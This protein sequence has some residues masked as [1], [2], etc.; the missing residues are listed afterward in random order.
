[1]H[2]LALIL[3]VALL[4]PVPGRITPDLEDVLSRTTPD[5]KIVV[6]IHMS[7]EY[8]Y[9]ELA[10]MTNEDK[11]VVMKDV[12]LNS[13]RDIT[14]YIR[15][16]PQAQAEMGGQF[17]IFNGFHVQ[18]TPA[19]IRN[20]AERPDV[21]FIC[22]NAT[23]QLDAMQSDDQ[24]PDLDA[25]EW[26][27]LKIKADSCWYAGFNGQNI[28]VG[29]VDTGVLTTHAALTGKWLSPYWVD[30]VNGQSSPYDD[31]SHGTHTMGTICGGDGPGAFTNDIGVAYGLR[32][33]P[34]KAFNSGGSGSYTSIDTCMH[35]LANLKSGG[36]DIRAIGNS[37]G[38][39]SGSELHYWTTVLNWKTL[40]VFP[41]FSNGNS[42]PSAGT[43]GAPGS[44]PLSCGVG[45]TT[46]TDAIA[47]YSS[48][49]PAPNISP[50][51]DPTY[52][53]YS[54][55]NL[56]KPDVSAPGS[57]IRS[58][59]NNGGYGSMDGTSMASPHVTGGAAVLLSKNSSLT[60]TDLYNL[61][62]NYCDQ[63]S[64]GG[65]YPNNNYGWGRI[66]LYRS[67]QNV[68]SGS[69]PNVT[70]NRTA[71][72]G[73]GN[74]NGKLDPGENAGIVAYLLNNGGASATNTQGTLRTTD[75]YITISDSTYTYGTIPAGDSANNTGDAF[76]LAVAG[77]CPVGHVV[78]FNLYIA[79]AESSWTRTFQLTVGTPG[80]DFATHDAGN[81]KLSIT[82]WGSIGFMESG[83]INGVGFV[84]PSAGTNKLF[85]SSF[86]IATDINYV[87][88]RYYDPNQVD[89]ADWVTTTSPDG[90]VVWEEPGP[91][92]RDEYSTAMYDDS[93]AEVVKNILCTQTTWG[94][95]DATANDF[96][97]MK[98]VLTNQSSG[99]INNIITG[100]FVDFDISSGGSSDYGGSEVA[101]NLTWM[102]QS[103]PYVGV[104]ILDPPRTTPAR[105]LV[106]I[107]NPTYVYPSSGMPDTLA[108]KFMN[109]TITNPTGGTAVDWSICNSTAPFNL[110]AGESHVV[111]Y[112]MIGGTSLADFQ[113]NADTAYQRYWNWGVAD[114]GQPV[115]G[116]KASFQITPLINH[117]G[118][119]TLSYA[120]SGESALNLTVYD[121]CGRNV[122]ARTW[123]R[124]STGQV[125]FELPEAAQ[126]VYFAKVEAGGQSQTVKLV[127][128]K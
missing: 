71:V 107:N 2:A 75:T 17:W 120:L 118:T 103:T 49:G 72:V 93:G 45:A 119:Y 80:L 110:N 23:V 11:C 96:V 32:F 70:L 34:T 48:R 53:Y 76:D 99:V 125:S 108:W 25:I 115:K 36:I 39:S 111:A 83:Q 117:L 97:I 102:Y 51:N 88:D 29:H 126:G 123:D 54:T 50:I 127:R 18:A 113:A 79:C 68:P 121:I 8:P 41:V 90:K 91:D 74:G 95:D 26:N 89:D 77:G 87:C 73:D 65:T 14:D 16:L 84:Y 101:R 42:G 1:M 69:T 12:A 92:S 62:R 56:L 21:W 15:T 10:A 67:L 31:H 98:Y 82:R 5:Q 35:Y 63:P 55:W 78:N 13:Q 52:W 3:A 44:Y 104:E 43:V 124:V 27:I 38:S 64:G 60:P 112:A 9:A 28:I 19:V 128:V 33:I 106:I 57:G 61:F 58:S 85:Y 20:L 7:T 59:L 30:G 116:P 109:G 37:W 86:A 105:N 94:W 47:S 122:Y 81:C 66:N 4:P 6:I 100:I 22:S 114:E 24:T 46:S 40:G